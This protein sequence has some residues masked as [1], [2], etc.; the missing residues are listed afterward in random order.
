MDAGTPG[1]GAAPGTVVKAARLWWVLA[2]ALYGC[3]DD[4]LPL[5]MELDEKHG[6]QT[7]DPVVFE[8][9]SVGEVKAIV[10]HTPRGYRAEVLIFGPHR[11]I[12]R[13]G[14]EFRIAADPARMGR[15]HVEIANAAEAGAA[16]EE[17]A[18]VRGTLDSGAAFAPFR[19]LIEGFSAGLKGL[20]DQAEALRRGL[21]GIPNSPEAQRLEEE[22]RRLLEEIAKAQAEAE[23]SLREE[24]LPRLQE[25]L[26]AL[27]KRLEELQRRERGPTTSV[28]T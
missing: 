1:H 3:G 12:A 20:A 6:L 26:E 27:K 11:G 4:P 17:G 21:E 15:K 10:P 28:G 22:W 2:L 13:A 14:S 18:T 23:E 9:Q 24:L 25:E 16:L 19:E 7:G 8:G 5:A